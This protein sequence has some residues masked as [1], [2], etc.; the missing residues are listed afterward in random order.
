MDTALTELPLQEKQLAESEPRSYVPKILLDDV[1]VL[2]NDHTVTAIPIAIAIDPV[3]LVTTECIT[4]TSAMRKH[5]RWAQSSVSAILGG[6]AYRNGLASPTSRI[7]NAPSK[8][9]SLR[10][11][12]SSTSDTTEDDGLS[13]RWGLRGKKGKSLQ[14]NPLMSAFARLRSDIRGCKGTYYYKEMS[15]NLT[16]NRYSYIRYALPS[17]SIPASDQVFFYFGAYNLSRS[18]RNHKIFRI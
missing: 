13:S 2:E 1:N 5:A 6:S 11:S 4:V 14:D 8:R 12:T 16:R 17:P 10:L 3:A 7:P 9:S 15:H 18:H